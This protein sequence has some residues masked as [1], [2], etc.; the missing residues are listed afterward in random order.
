[1]ERNHRDGISLR[2]VHIWLIIGAVFISGLM[3]LSTYHL[4]TSFRD[5]TETSEQQI[6]LRK[7]AREL[8]DAS[9]FLTENVQRFTVSGDTRFLDAYFAEA[10]EANHR[11]EAI[12]RMSESAMHDAALKKLQDAMSDSLELM[13]Q[14]YYAM[15]LVLEAKGYSE[16]PEVLKSVRL[17][18]EDKA[19]P[20]EEKMR[21]A[22]ELVLNDDYY[23]VKDRIRASMK[24]SLDALEQ[25][26]YDADASALVSL[27]D[28]MLLVRIVIVIQT[29]GII[30]MVWLTS[31][32]G[33]HPVLNAV[34]RIKADSP[35]PEVGANEFRY[36]ARAYN[37]MYEVYR[38]SLERLNFK[39]SHDKLTGAYNRSGYDLLLSSVDLS[40]TYMLLFDLDN[41]K[42]IND[43]Y[44]HETGDRVL[45]KLVKVLKNNFRS[46]DYICRIGGDEFVVFMVHS[47]EKQRDMIAQ[48]IEKINAE[49]AD[50]S[51]GLPATSISVGIVHGTEAADAVNL[52]ERTDAAMYQAKRSGK[53]T[54]HFSGVKPKH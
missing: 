35:I 38:N 18:G 16:Y 14:E 50:T 29:L 10:F 15:R 20:A 8:M 33:I 23:A 6:Q 17:T 3:F 40:S 30:F 37:K 48:K 53:H 21:R 2:T 31:R 41:F 24:E 26:A 22:T 27:R 19:L 5:L 42:G 52:F 44:G 25:M 11:E 39:A 45:T 28:E 49:L 4:S 1:M 7:A 12:A 51:D 32:L 36:L 34:E 13:N 9:D 47:M 54:Y 43:T 46:D